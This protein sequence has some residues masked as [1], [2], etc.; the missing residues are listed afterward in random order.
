MSDS[1]ALNGIHRTEIC[2]AIIGQL[3]AMTNNSHDLLRKYSEDLQALSAQAQA[4]KKQRAP[5]HQ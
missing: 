1:L 2:E 4:F 3:T 5:A